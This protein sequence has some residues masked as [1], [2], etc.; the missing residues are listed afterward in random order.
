MLQF[1]NGGGMW[2]GRGVGRCEK[3]K[4]L[5]MYFPQMILGVCHKNK[6]LLPK[7]LFQKSIVFG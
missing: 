4:S 2:L 1:F 3:V 6:T 7:K 5:K